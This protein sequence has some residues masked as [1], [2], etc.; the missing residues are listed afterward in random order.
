MVDRYN[1]TSSRAP[2]CW[3]AKHKAKQETETEKP[4]QNQNKRR[5]CGLHASFILPVAA[6]CNAAA[7]LGCH[8]S[9]AVTS[10]S[11]CSPPPLCLSDTLLPCPLPWLTQTSAGCFFP[12]CCWR[13][14]WATLS[15]LGTN[16]KNVR[17]KNNI[18]RNI[19]C[20]M[21]SREKTIKLRGV[22]RWVVSN[23]AVHH[24]CACT[25]RYSY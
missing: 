12:K 19:P 9:T 7:P 23:S 22:G 21:T 8:Q 24:L 2:R 4:E 25:L 5:Y 17:L 14:S 6:S 15:A 13:K 10:A 1:C 3:S 11:R 16:E 20:H 18:Q